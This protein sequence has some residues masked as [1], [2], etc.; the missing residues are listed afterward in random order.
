MEI[1]EGFGIGVDDIR[2]AALVTRFDE[3]FRGRENK[4]ILRHR[5][6]NSRQKPEEEIFDFIKRM[7]RLASQSQLAN[8]ESDITV[9]AIIKR[10]E[11]HIVT[12]SRF[13]H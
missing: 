7:K 11:V 10:L 9:Q 5:L 2:Y 1:F 12:G 6:F 8:L 13:R 4:N 3:Y